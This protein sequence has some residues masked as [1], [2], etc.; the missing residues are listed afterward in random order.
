VCHLARGNGD[1][2]VLARSVKLPGF[3]R[4]ASK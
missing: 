3:A 1:L 2:H 4:A